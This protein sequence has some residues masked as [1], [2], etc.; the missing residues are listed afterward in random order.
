M[1]LTVLD[2]LPRFSANYHANSLKYYAESIGKIPKGIASR[3]PKLP[4]LNNLILGKFSHAVL[5]P[6]L[7][8]NAK[9]A[10]GSI[11]IFGRHVSHVFFVCPQKKMIG[12]YASWI[13]AAMKDKKIVGNFSYMN[14]I[15]SP[16]CADQ[17]V[18]TGAFCNPYYPIPTPLF[19]PNPNPTAVGFLDELKKAFRKRF[20][21]WSHVILFTRTGTT[22]Q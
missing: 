9:A 10:R 6:A 22:C 4:N 5:F 15:R 1:G 2:V 16:M 11:T 8:S 19:G 21:F 14:F 18:F 17:S 13:V 12:V 3:V 20:R 7:I